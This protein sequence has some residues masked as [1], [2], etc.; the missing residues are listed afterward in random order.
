MSIFESDLYT[1]GPSPGNTKLSNSKFAYNQFYKS[2]N[3]NV[4]MNIE[5]D[6]MDL[7]TSIS[8]ELDS[9]N[10][11]QKR[12]VSHFIEEMT[13]AR[14]NL[15]PWLSNLILNYIRHTQ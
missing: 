5:N 10:K 13:S 14:P 12:Y 1:D 11:L 3:Q 6:F 4:K 7:K 8:K 15:D 9:I 2:F